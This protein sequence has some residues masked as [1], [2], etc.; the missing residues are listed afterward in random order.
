MAVIISAIISPIRAQDCRCHVIEPNQT[1]NKEKNTQT[2][3]EKTPK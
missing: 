2:N 1:G 3:A